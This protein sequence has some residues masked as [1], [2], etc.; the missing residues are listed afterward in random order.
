MIFLHICNIQY[1]PSAQLRCWWS[2]SKLITLKIC[3]WLD[4]TDNLKESNNHRRLIW[5]ILL[6]FLSP[7]LWSPLILQVCM[8]V[9]RCLY[10]LL[11]I[12]KEEESWKNE[13]DWGS[14]RTSWKS[15]SDRDSR[16]DCLDCRKHYSCAENRPRG[17][18]STFVAT[19]FISFF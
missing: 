15:I 3:E 19:R 7:K 6:I 2:C 13:S 12:G 8:Q 9:V 1:Q 5:L 16:R 11:P 14:Y 18:H 10:W 4:Q 17:T